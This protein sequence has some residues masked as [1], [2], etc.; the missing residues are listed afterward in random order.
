MKNNYNLKAKLLA[1][2]MIASVALGAASLAFAEDTSVSVSAHSSTTI[3][4]LRDKERDDIKGI[5]ASSTAEMK[6]EHEEMRDMHA[7]TTAAVKAIHEA[8]KIAIK[9]KLDA[10]KQIQVRK[11]IGKHIAA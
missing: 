4:M 11:V 8:T 10:R 6:M 7:S 1:G 3:K 5:R 9:A 2:T